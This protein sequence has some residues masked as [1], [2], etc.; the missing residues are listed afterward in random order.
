MVQFIPQIEQIMNEGKKMNHK[1]DLQRNSNTMY[2]SDD[3]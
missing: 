2:F 3:I 1:N